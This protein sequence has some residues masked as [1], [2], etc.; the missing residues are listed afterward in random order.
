M[1]TLPLTPAVNV[2]YNLPAIGTPRANFNLGLIVGTSTVISTGTRVAVY[3]SLAEMATAGFS[4][5]SPEYLAATRYFAANSRPRQVA[6][7]RQGTGE[8]AVAALTACRLAN[9][10]WYTAFVPGASDSDSSAIAAYVEAL[11]GPLTQYIFQSSTSAIKAGTGGNLFETLKTSAYK[12]TLGIFSTDAYIGAAVMGYAMGQVSNLANSAFTLKFK[13]LPGATDESLTTAQVTTIEG[14]NGNVYIQRIKGK[15]WFEN[16]T[17]F[18]GAFFDEILYYD[19]LASDIQAAI[20][21]QLYRVN[22]LPQTD[23]GMAQL[24]SV[25][26]VPCQQGVK[27][28]YLAPGQWNGQPVLNLNPGD[29]LSAGYLIQSDSIDNQSQVDREARKAPNIYAA[30]K[31]AGAIH[32]VVIEIDVNR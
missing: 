10:D 8:T 23:D 21:D 6:I 2:Y 13:N 25:V 26:S 30:V 12:R 20:A 22:K 5:N 32:S 11:T 9:T 16:G 18:S 14:N 4:L 31:G 3:S 27:M 17:S 28:G 29:N 19:K 24:R 7:G 1:P 15:P